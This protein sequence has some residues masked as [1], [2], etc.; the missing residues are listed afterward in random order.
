MEKVC[1]K[2]GESKPINFFRI[3]RAKADG[4]QGAC[5]SCLAVL[6][7]VYY[8]ANAPKINRYSR[9]WRK[10]HPEYNKLKLKDWHL[11]RKQELTQLR[12]DSEMLKQLL[13]N[14]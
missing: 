6:A 1:K 13:A 7:K 10:E 3:D 9:K 2:C 4:H 8:H 12:K 5:K 14:K 11:K